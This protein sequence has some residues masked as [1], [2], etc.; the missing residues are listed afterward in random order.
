[1]QTDSA[2]LI[3]IV[4]DNPDNLRVLF[5]FLTDSDFRVLVATNGQD[6][7]N[8][9]QHITPNLILLDIMM[10]VMDGF[11][12]CRLLKLDPKFQDIPII[13][14][15]ALSDT[16]DKIEGLNLGAV[17]YITKPF[18][19][20]E[21]LIRIRLHLKLRHLTQSLQE[22]NQQLSQEIVARQVAESELQKLNQ[23]LEQRIIDRTQAL[24]LALNKLIQREKKLIYTAFHDSV[25]AVFNRAWLIQFLSEIFSQQ[26]LKEDYEILF[27]DLDNFKNVND[28]FGHSIGDKLLQQVVARLYE[29]IELQGEIVRL[30]GDEFLIILQNQD[31]IETLEII[32]KSILKQLHIPFKIH[33]Y[34][35]SIGV[36]I[37]ILPSILNYRQPTDILRDADAAMYEAKHSG[38][39]RYVV[40]SSEMQARILERI[41]LESDLRKSIEEKE[42]YLDYQPI[43]SLDTQKLVGFEALVRWLHPKHGLI[44]P[45]KFITVAEELGIIHNLDL[46]SLQLACQQLHQWKKSFSLGNFLIINVNLSFV[47]MQ[48]IELAEQIKQILDEYQISPI[49]I[50]LEVT[51]SALIEEFSVATQILKR[52][53]DLGIK[54][55]MDDFGTGYSSFSQLH[56]FPINTIKIDRS[57]TERLDVSIEGMAIVKTIISFA[58]CL[59]MDVVA[60]GIETQT[61]L[62]KL[63]ELG[64]DFGQGYLLSKPLSVQQANDILSNYFSNQLEAV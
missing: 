55:C 9:L 41:Q 33:S 62:E 11:E 24:N 52:I 19:Q 25:T 48:Q 13:F 60:E 23:N 6:A 50:K 35:I 17:D 10:P 3:L 16:K 18:Q 61:Q 29:C 42:F 14:M 12:I 21:V 7:L 58:K 20:E 64:C 63:K 56:K 8:K 44:Y 57:F 5:T 40:F 30:G 38:K 4:D 47:Q 37:G 51:E 1:M 46:L 26:P 53:N 59:G 22:N 39:G 43:F 34:Q 49:M 31:T 2:D 32:A 54:L 36:S 15:S 27:L 45:E 28:R